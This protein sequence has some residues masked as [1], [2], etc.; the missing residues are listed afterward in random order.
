MSKLIKSMTFSVAALVLS[1]NVVHSASYCGEKV[2][3]VIVHGDGS[4]YFTTDQSCSDNWCKLDFEDPKQVDR[5]YSM[6]LS[7]TIADR[8]VDFS[9]PDISSCDEKNANHAS[10]EYLDIRP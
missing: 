6:L 10:P 4:V 9:W 5:G 8:S 1:S 7:A 3:R 2:A